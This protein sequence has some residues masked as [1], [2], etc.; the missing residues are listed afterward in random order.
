MVGALYDKTGYDILRKKNSVLFLACKAIHDP[1]TECPIRDCSVL[2]FLLDS[3]FHPDLYRAT[4][5]STPGHL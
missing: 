2:Y 4:S 3:G 1:E 5:T